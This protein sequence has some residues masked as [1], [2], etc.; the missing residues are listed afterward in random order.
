MSLDVQ[1]VCSTKELENVLGNSLCTWSVRKSV[2]Y[3]HFYFYFFSSLSL[4]FSV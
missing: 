1:L 2:Q 4:Y 3:Y